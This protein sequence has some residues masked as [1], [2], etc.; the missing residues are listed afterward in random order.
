MI[1]PIAAQARFDFI[2]LKKGVA[3]VARTN[4]ASSRPLRAS[5][6]FEPLGNAR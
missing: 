6:V 4:N 1:D 5:K 2:L 3:I